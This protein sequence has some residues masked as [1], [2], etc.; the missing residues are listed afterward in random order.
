MAN[1]RRW[2]HWLRYLLLMVVLL[3]S[4]AA[5]ALALIPDTVIALS[6]VLLVVATSAVAG[7]GV[8]S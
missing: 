1:R 7:W 4:S 2:P 8:T 5:L 6:L 3:V